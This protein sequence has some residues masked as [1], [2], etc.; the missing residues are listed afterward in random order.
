MQNFV[1]KAV[2]P[3]AAVTVKQTLQKGTVVAVKA[4][5]GPRY[6]MYLRM[7]K[8]ACSIILLFPFIVV[9]STNPQTESDLTKDSEPHA[10]SEPNVLKYSVAPTLSNTGGMGYYLVK[11]SGTWSPQRVANLTNENVEKVYVD[12]SRRIIYFAALAPNDISKEGAPKNNTWE[13]F[14]GLGSNKERT[15]DFYNV[16]ASSFTSVSINPGEA[17]IGNLFNVLAATVRYRVYIDQSALLKAVEDSGLIDIAE[18]D[19]YVHY[20]K[21]YEAAE[22]PTSLSNWLMTYKNVYDPDN[23]APEASTRLKSLLARDEDIRRAEASKRESDAKILAA[24]KLAKI[25]SWRKNLKVGDDTFCGPVIEIR[26]NLAKIS[27]KSPLAGYPGEVWVRSNELY[28][29]GSAVCRNVNNQI[30]PV[31]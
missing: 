21:S 17:V 12:A 24:E 28:P 4:E 10:Y 20:R 1:L 3:K 15:A 30:S 14:K 9:A 27:L 2:N 13:C 29:N 26:S 22:T 23:L 19:A 5:A 7:K 18:K 6:L 8:T 16:C 11:E 31:F 25:Q